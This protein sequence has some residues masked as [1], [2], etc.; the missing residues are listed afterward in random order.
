MS[1]ETGDLITKTLGW[2]DGDFRGKAFVG[3]EVEGETRVV[4]F[5]KVARS[6]LDCLCTNTTLHG[7]EI[8][9]SM[10]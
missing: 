10:D 6:T 2:D 7:H 8:F 1:G 9:T 3:L 4:L 5:D